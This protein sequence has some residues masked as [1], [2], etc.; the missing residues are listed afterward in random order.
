M[1]DNKEEKC[2]ICDK[3]G[4]AKMKILYNSERVT[5]LENVCH[6][7]LSLGQVEMDKVP[8][9]RGLYDKLENKET[10]ELKKIGYHN[11]CVKPIVNNDNI[12]LLRDRAKA[13][14]SQ[15]PKGC[16][17]KNEDAPSHST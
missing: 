2:T 5:K 3:P 12:Q 14:K 15:P 10:S 4:K 6:E 9:L 7:R 11:Q 16:K 8:S 1:A 13:F 17:R